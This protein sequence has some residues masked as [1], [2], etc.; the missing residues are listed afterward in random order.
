MNRRIDWKKY[1]GI[2]VLALTGCGYFDYAVEPVKTVKT[3]DKLP[4]ESVTVK[5]ENKAEEPWAKPCKNKTSDEG[6]YKAVI[7]STDGKEFHN[8]VYEVDQFNHPSDRY[9]TC[10]L[11]LDKDTIVYDNGCDNK[12]DSIFSFK[13]GRK[14][15]RTELEEWGLADFF[16]KKLTEA[17][18]YACPINL[19]KPEAIESVEKIVEK[20]R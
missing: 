20:Y 12:I 3:P 19:I 16:E 7:W 15:F 8:V 10:E 14:V 13:I 4:S 5:E 9:L 6:K 1:A 2:G 17:S 11:H 18:L